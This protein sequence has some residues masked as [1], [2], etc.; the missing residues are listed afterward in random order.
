MEKK[1]CYVGAE[2]WWLTKAR[3]ANS[4]MR[5]SL[6]VVRL[7]L[8]GALRPCEKSFRRVRCALC[9]E[10]AYADVF[11]R[12][13]CF[14]HGA[15]VFGEGYEN[16]FVAPSLRPARAGPASRFF[17]SAALHSSMANLRY[18]IALAK[19]RSTGRVGRYRDFL[20]NQGSGVRGRRRG[21]V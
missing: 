6:R 10:K 2:E 8:C 16:G 17:T 15:L 1:Y 21:L 18:D 12:G 11:P 4:D 19:H 3:R 5:M 14:D 7:V 13:G 9:H 20:R